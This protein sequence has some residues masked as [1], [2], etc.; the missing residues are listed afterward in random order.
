M[1]ASKHAI[2]ALHE[3][4]DG[5]GHEAA[6]AILVLRRGDEAWAYRNVCP[7]F[8]IPLNYEPDAFWTYGGGLLMCAHH[9]AMFRFEDGECIDG[10][11]LGARL[12]RVAI[13]IEDGRVVIDDESI[14]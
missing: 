9:S 10:P 5:G 1:N 4:P 11:C 12:E 6:P 3:V 7:H 8:S 2:C 13:R 14:T